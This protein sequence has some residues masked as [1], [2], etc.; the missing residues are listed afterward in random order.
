MNNRTSIIIVFLIIPLV[1]SLT[2]C[3][4]NKSLISKIWI[5]KELKV[6]GINIENRLKTYA[7]R[8]NPKIVF[9]DQK[10]VSLPRLEDIHLSPPYYPN[11]WEFKRNGFDGQ[12]EIT[13]NNQK[14][15]SGIYDIEI[16]NYNHPKQI[17]LYS[18]SIEFILIEEQGFSLNNRMIPH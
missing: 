9:H 13:D 8:P 5:I 2:S 4:E 10:T 3:D 15:F 7:L 17:R 11:N 6:N 14:Y 1:F 12:V 18:D 16:I